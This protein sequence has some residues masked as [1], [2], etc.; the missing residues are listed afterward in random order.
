MLGPRGDGGTVTASGSSNFSSQRTPQK[1]CSREF[2]I[3]APALPKA[4][5]RA[6]VLVV[7]LWYLKLGR[8]LLV[9]LCRHE[10]GH[11]SLDLDSCQLELSL[12]LCD[13]TTGLSLQK[14][15]KRRLCTSL[16]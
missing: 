8:M 3:D 14:G 7:N 15:G 6:R 11:C 4:G 1:R 12:C 5:R 10:V 2:E 16:R 9:Q 13:Q